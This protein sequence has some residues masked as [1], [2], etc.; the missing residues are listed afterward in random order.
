MK[1]DLFT[2][3]DYASNNN[4]R[5]CIIDTFDEIVADN[6]PWRAY[7]GVAL[8]LRISEDEKNGGE[9]RMIIAD[10]NGVD[11]FNA[12]TPLTEGYGKLTMAGNIKGLIFD[13]PGEYKFTVS[14]NGSVIIEKKFDVIKKEEK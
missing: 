2:L 6:F 12:I 3:C 14:Y 5:L 9:V 1:V 8:K 4:G 11:I 13:I 10:E 7:F